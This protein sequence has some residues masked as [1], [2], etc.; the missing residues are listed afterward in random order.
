[1]FCNNHIWLKF[2][3][4]WTRVSLHWSIKE[5]Y[6]NLMWSVRNIGSTGKN[7]ELESDL[8]GT[9]KC[10]KNERPK[11]QPPVLIEI[12]VQ[13]VNSVCTGLFLYSHFHSNE[14]NPKEHH[15]KQSL[16]WIMSIQGS[17]LQSQ[18]GG[19]YLIQKLSL[20]TGS[21]GCKWCKLLFL[22]LYY[23]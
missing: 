14:T 16:V 18:T 6:I 9:N 23:I 11:C 8:R 17:R 3:L 21:R 10:A 5:F 4:C 13:G 15:Q 12:D 20:A 22:R 19:M 7:L 2:F 1:V